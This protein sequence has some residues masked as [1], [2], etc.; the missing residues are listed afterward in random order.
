MADQKERVKFWVFLCGLMLA[1][2]VMVT[3]ID[4]SIK[5]SILEQANNFRIDLEGARGQNVS[6]ANT[7]GTA[8]HVAD[9]GTVPSN[10]LDLQPTGL[11]KGDDPKKVPFQ[12]A[13]AAGP[14]RRR[15]RAGDIPASTDPSV[16]DK[17][18][19]A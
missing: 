18:M 17:P 19:G 5:A 14:A 3:L 11:G 9:N 12:G 10:V 15:A 16:H 2:A 8:N 1:V 6:G 13:R 4:I 7:N